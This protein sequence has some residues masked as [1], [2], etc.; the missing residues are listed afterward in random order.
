MWVTRA[1]LRAALARGDW[2]GRADGAGPCCSRAGSPSPA[3]CWSPGPRSAEHDASAPGSRHIVPASRTPSAARGNP[4]PR[5]CAGCPQVPTA[6]VAGAGEKWSAWM[7]G[8]SVS[9]AAPC[10]WVL[11]RRGT[12]SD[13]DRRADRGAP[14]GIRRGST[15]RRPGRPTRARGASRA[16]EPRGRVGG[17]PCV[18]SVGPPAPGLVRSAGSGARDR[19][20]VSGGRRGRVVHVHVAPLRPDEIVVVDGIPVTSVARTVVDMARWVI[21]ARGG[22]RRRRPQARGGGRGGPV[23]CVGTGARL[24]GHASTQ[25]AVTFADGGSESVGE[26]RSRVAVARAGL[27]APRYCSG[28]CAGV[29]A[30]GSGAW[31]SAGPTGGR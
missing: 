30:G 8:Y 25:R 14:R 18:G 21:S 23:G 16:R 1:E 4:Q 15:A 27:P 22:D 6:G 10:R 13:P 12:H 7:N 28:T 31:T 29:P 19:H 2:G 3:R 26:S 11:R 9:A 24:A 17:E 5:A 20:R